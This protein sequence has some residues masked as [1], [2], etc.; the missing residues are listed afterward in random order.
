MWLAFTIS[1]R[2]PSIGQ[3]TNAATST[4]TPPSPPWRATLAS[5]WVSKGR[6]R[7]RLLRAQFASFLRGHEP[8]ARF[9]ALSHWDVG[10]RPPPA[11]GGLGLATPP[12][13]LAAKLTLRTVPPNPSCS[14]PREGQPLEGRAFTFPPGP[15][16]ALSIPGHTP[17]V[18]GLSRQ[19]MNTSLLVYQTSNHY[20]MILTCDLPG[21]DWRGLAL[22]TH[23]GTSHGAQLDHASS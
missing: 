7:H 11:P 2:V 16:P 5:V 3:A 12:P 4:L 6:E 22:S 8:Q 23:P 19:Q 1:S 18:Q 20:Q 17:G 21:P 13:G 10:R 14:P 9:L 15:S